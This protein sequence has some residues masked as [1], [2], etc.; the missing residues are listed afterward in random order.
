MTTDTDRAEGQAQAQL[1]GIIAMM[2]R[3]NHT[4]SCNG[5]DCDL[6]DGEILD[7][8]NLVGKGTTEDDRNDYHDDESALT[9]IQEDPLS[10]QLRSGWHSL[11]EE[12][13]DEE[14]EIL[15]CMGGPACRIIGELGEYNSAASAC[16]QYQ[17]W[18]TPWTELIVTGD[19]HATL[20]AYADQ[21][22]GWLK[23]LEIF[24]ACRRE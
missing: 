5:A 19:D 22:L 14:Y 11:G 23:Y 4:Q 1:E 20:V 15:L 21:Q 13:E 12:S 18:G 8:L 24:S 7:G 2:F 3:L 16:L 9:A 17:D 10:V 6:T